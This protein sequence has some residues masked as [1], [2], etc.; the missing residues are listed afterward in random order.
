M[1]PLIRKRKAE[2]EAEQQSKEAKIIEPI[3]QQVTNKAAPYAGKPYSEQLLLKKKEMTKALRNLTKEIEKANF[4]AL[5]LIEKQKEVNF[6]CICEFAE[7]IS[8]PVIENYRNK[9][10]FTAGTLKNHTTFIFSGML[11]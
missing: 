2:K 5:S 11:R 9:C 8:S 10:E 4:Q 3:A 6:G 7:M 1:D